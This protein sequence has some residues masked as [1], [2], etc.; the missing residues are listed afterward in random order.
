MLSVERKLHWNRMKINV[1]MYPYSV[2][3]L[4]PYKRD[5]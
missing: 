3:S 1:K 5:I 2:K 4:N